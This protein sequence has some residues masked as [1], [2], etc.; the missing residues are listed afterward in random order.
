MFVNESGWFSSITNTKL[1]DFEDCRIR[2][3]RAS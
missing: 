3:I 2:G 1:P